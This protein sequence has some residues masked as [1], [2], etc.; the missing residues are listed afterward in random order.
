MKKTKVPIGQNK[1]LKPW[2]YE[3]YVYAFA[4]RIFRWSPAYRN[5]TK[6]ATRPGNIRVC[7]KCEKPFPKRETHVDHVNPV[8]DPT[9]GFTTWESYFGR[10]YVGVDQLQVLCKKDHKVKTKAEN[11]IRYAVRDLKKR[12][13]AKAAKEAEVTNEAA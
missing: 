2:S 7:A 11:K 3:R 8:I 1:K 4:R 13:I 5:V 6:L 9:T 10:L 12:K